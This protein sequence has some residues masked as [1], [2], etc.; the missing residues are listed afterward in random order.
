[1]QLKRLEIKG[2]KSFAD[3]TVIDFTDGITAVVGPNG[4]GKS[5]IIEAIRWVMGEQSAKTLRGGRMHDIIF[6]GTDSRKAINIA[7]VTLILDNSDSFLPIDFEEVSIGRRLNRN[8]DSDYYI[9]KESCRLKDVVD[10]FMDSGLGKESFSIISQGQVEAVFNSKAED[11][12][13][14]FE[15]AAG[16]FKYKLQKEKAERKLFETQDNLDR[17]QDILYE[18]NDQLE[19]L[20]KQKDIAQSFV[21]QKEELTDLDIALSVLK[22][23]QYAREQKE[24]KA[25]IEALNEDLRRVQT[26]LDRESTELKEKR[27]A[28][29]DIEDKREKLQAETITSVQQ[30]ERTEAQLRLVEEKER[31]QDAF[32]SEKQGSLKKEETRL[33]ALNDEYESLKQAYQKQSAHVTDLKNDVKKYDERLARLMGNKEEAIEELRG[34]YIDAMQ[35]KTSLKNEEMYLER[36]RQQATINAEKHK[37]SLKDVSQKLDE[38]RT[39]H[40][41]KEAALLAIK[42]EIDELLETYTS[43]KALMDDTQGSFKQKADRLNQLNHQLQR[44]QAK[45][46]S[47]KEMQEN[48]AGYF[49]GVKAVMRGK[50]NLQGIVGTVADMMDV[51][52][53][54]TEAIDVVLGA[55]SQ[56]VIVEDEKS[57]RDAISYLKNKKAGRA[58]FLPLTTIKKRFVSPQMRQKAQNVD[59]FIGIASDL[60]HFDDKVRNVM[61]NLLGQ[62]IVAKD[63]HSANAIAKALRYSVRIVSLDGDVMNAGGSMTGGGGKRSSN[64]HLFS[65][66]KEQ[67]ALRI[68]I[69]ELEKTIKLR[70]DENQTDRDTIESLTKDLEELRT[71]GEDKRLEERQLEQVVESLS[72]TVNRLERECKGL[73]YEQQ[74][75]EKEETQV[76]TDLKEVKEKR[77]RAESDLERLKHEL[78]QLTNEKEDKQVQKERLE[79]EREELSEQW[80]AE[81][82]TLA[83]TRSKR[84][85]VEAQIRE[86]DQSIENL[87]AELTQLE[88]GVELESKEDL[89]EKLETLQKEAVKLKAQ[90]SDLKES[91]TD[92]DEMVSQLDE[93][94]SYAIDYKAELTDKKNQL[95][96]A[97]SRLDV[98]MDH[99]LA[100]LSEEY[101]TSYEEAKSIQPDDIDAEATQKRVK[102]LKRGIEELGP[103]N[104][105]AIE[106]YERVAERHDFLAA[107]QQDLL[108]AKEKLYD[109]MDQMDSEVERRFY[110]TF[111]QVKEQFA[112]VFP[113]MFGGGKAELRLTDPDDLLHSGI[114]IIAQPPGKRLQSLSLLSGGERALTALSLLFAIIQVKPIPFCILDEAEAALDEA[115]VT[116]FGR[117]LH[118]FAS[119]TQFIVITHRKGTME[120]ADSLYGVTMREKGVSRLVSVHLQ[121]I[122][123]TVTQ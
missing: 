16:V 9:N 92:L 23:D 89:G 68:E 29:H 40:T 83:F 45:Q 108:E 118:E 37:T 53:D 12:R 34:A 25:K 42:T 103:V 86:V 47:L 28:L 123:E 69:D 107:Q 44:A 36:E 17:V 97:Q 115:N 41:E 27:A 77:V 52:T 67:K 80:N 94:V 43:K 64:A 60:I 24:N 31:H 121:D 70:E 49:A 66:K 79:Q 91:H 54:V 2:F 13:A 3:K 101:T 57:G 110:E 7:E 99:L 38:A 65:Q 104:V 35:N 75:A 19:P 78:D 71:S 90:E 81:R 113:R 111:S 102:L 116:R 33:A 5:N 46:A 120:E 50:D 48:Y 119:E 59:G 95:D 21:S 84:E 72:E 56:F 32:L 117:Y 20:K 30:I 73:R 10:L 58:T 93:S 96:I 74:E 39:S 22:I 8:G 61:E 85:S 122:E 51:P 87:K 106:E 112:L 100:Y 26:K 6:S 114:E 1:M 82:E 4:S 55:A 76:N 109:T 18:L 63:L 105:G 62:T 88:E 98:S 14:I 15:E 11:R